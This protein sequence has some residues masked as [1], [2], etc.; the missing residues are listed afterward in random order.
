V[1]VVLVLGAPLVL[2]VFGPHYAE[3]G[4]GALVL[5]SLSA[6][7]NVVT[8]S[9][10]SAARVR[11]R[12]GVLFGVPATVS[13][14]VFVMSWLLMPALGIT[15]VGLAWLVAQLLVAGG[16]LVATAPWLPPL[17][18]TRIDTVR[19]A[20]LLR[21]VRPFAAA[22]AGEGGWVLGERLA[23]RSDSVVVGFGPEMG[24]VGG[25][26]ALLKAS[27]S[28]KG[29]A[30]LRRQT[31]VLRS[32]QADERLGPWRTMVPMVLGAG[33]VGGSYAVLESRLP[34]ESGGHALE[35]PVRRRVFRSSAIATITEMHRC[36]A[37][38]VR[39][40]E[41]ELRRWV[42][43]PMS[44]VIGALPRGHRAAGRALAD[45]I[46]DRIR[47][48]L[49][50]CGR[51][52][53]DFTA[54]N[55]L[56]DP[57]GCVLAV[58]DWC[59]AH[60]AGLPVLDLVC[61]QLTAENLT[62]GT[63]IGVL[64]LDRL[65]DARAPEHELLARAQRMLGGE[66]LDMGTLTLLGWLQHVAQNIQKSPTFAGNP[67]WVRRNLVAV[68]RGALPL[69]DGAPAVEPSPRPDDAAPGQ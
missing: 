24:T 52:H 15:A 59:Q 38:P 17:L 27:D 63:E 53:G 40:G 57:D 6:I 3:Y 37:A 33:D 60:D 32:M 18:S 65:R 7:P 48:R 1:V 69:L 66:V 26:G 51:T 19:T 11:Q 12:M 16:I 42:H 14:L 58:V 46:A 43:E 22:Q 55:V 23:G 31:D 5:A 10:V 9:T 62:T 25:P 8:A 50:S 2:S 64:V 44:D 41:A 28:T 45:R 34:G 49:V 13:M 61:F 29:R 36:T 54:D 30:Q 20:A 39:V 67:V 35:D 47:G 68:V 4:T 56:T 21:R